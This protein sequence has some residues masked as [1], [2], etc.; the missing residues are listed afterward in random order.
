MKTLNTSFTHKLYGKACLIPNIDAKPVKSLKQV[1]M[2]NWVSLED[3]D[4]ILRVSG[5]H[6]AGLICEGRI[7]QPNIT[8]EM[9]KILGYIE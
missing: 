9:L 3:L 5:T 6:D 7:L 2:I 1:K 4:G 8:A